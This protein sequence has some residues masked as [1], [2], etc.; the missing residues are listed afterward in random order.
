MYP[1]Q[2]S[3]GF[4]GVGAAFDGPKVPSE[5]HVVQLPRWILALGPNEHALQ[6]QFFHIQWLTV[7]VLETA[8]GPGHGFHIVFQSQD[9]TLGIVE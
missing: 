7:R 5:L 8:H 4:V 6:F 1:L 9:N 2:K 3:L